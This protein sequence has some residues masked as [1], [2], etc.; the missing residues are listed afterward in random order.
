MS[1]YWHDSENTS[2]A[3]S[4]DYYQTGDLFELDAHGNFYFRGR[5]DAMMKAGGVKI[6]PAEIEAAIFA[7]P[8]VREA[9]VVP[10]DDRLRGLVP[11]AVI[12]SEPGESITES[13]IRSFLKDRISKGKLPK[14]FRFLPDLPRTASGKVDRKALLSFS[15]LDEKPSEKSLEHR[16]DAIDLKILHLLNE[17]MRIEKKLMEYNDGTGFQPERTQET[18]QRIL[19]FNP[20]PLHD[21]IVE[22][23]FRSLLS[24]RTLYQD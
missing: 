14:I 10:F 20:G 6:Y 18:I 13:Q 2:K 9:V 21:S 23:I 24:L 12:V 8:L 19:E 16:L 5:M 1:G 17:R 3:F 4:G 11:M 7:H 22:Q 15:G